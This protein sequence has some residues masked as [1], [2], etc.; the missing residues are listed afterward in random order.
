LWWELVAVKQGMLVG[1]VR[2]VVLEAADGLGVRDQL[3]RGHL[4]AFVETPPIGL[5]LTPV[6]PQLLAEEPARRLGALGTLR[7]RRSS[8]GEPLRQLL[9][10]ALPFLQLG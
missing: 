6:P 9:D 1:S 8:A 2:A 7:R 10:L 3:V 4:Q 5:L